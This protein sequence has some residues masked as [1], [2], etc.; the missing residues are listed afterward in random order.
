[1]IADLGGAIAVVY[2]AIVTLLPTFLGLLLGI[3]VLGALAE[4]CGMDLRTLDQ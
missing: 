2:G 4:A 3:G 1:M